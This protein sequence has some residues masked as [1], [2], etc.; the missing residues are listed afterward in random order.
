MPPHTAVRGRPVL[1]AV[2]S[3]LADGQ[4]MFPHVAVTARGRRNIAR[5]IILLTGMK[6]V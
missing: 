2:V 5:F 3:V 6:P 4:T 1:A